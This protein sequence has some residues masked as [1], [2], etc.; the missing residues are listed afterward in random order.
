[1]TSGWRIV[2]R[3][4][5]KHSYKFKNNI[6]IKY[7]VIETKKGDGPWTPYIETSRSTNTKTT[8]EER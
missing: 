1:M 3:N 2:K 7:K 5:K 8:P 4:R 6:E